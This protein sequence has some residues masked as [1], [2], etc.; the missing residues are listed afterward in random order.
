MKKGQLFLDDQE[1]YRKGM[2]FKVEKPNESIAGSWWCRPTRKSKAV[3]GGLFSYR[4]S[5]IESRRVT[6][7]AI[8]KDRA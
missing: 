3:G 7:S 8:R 6:K 5:F 1:G 4:E 2:I